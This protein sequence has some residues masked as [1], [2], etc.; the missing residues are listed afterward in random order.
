MSAKVSTFVRVGGAPYRYTFLLVAWNDYADGVRD[1]LNR[2]SEAFGADLGPDGLFVQPYTQRMHETAGEVLAKAWPDDVR[3]RLAADPDPI[4]LVLDEAFADFDPREHGYAILWLS[5]YHGDPQEVR[6]ALQML[7]RRTKA[8]EDLIAF[9]A[10]AARRQQRATAGDAAAG[11]AAR[12]A[13]Y[14]E[15]KPRIFGVSIDLRAVLRDL[16]DRR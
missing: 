15:V 6:P 4:L 5:D 7:A 12:L 3:E 13:S 16:A 9:L 11:V 14:V 10:D 1:E 2:Q 8:G